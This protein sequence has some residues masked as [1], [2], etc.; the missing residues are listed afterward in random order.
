MSST[1]PVLGQVVNQSPTTY[2]RRLIDKPDGLRPVGDVH[3]HRE[4]RFAG[5]R[6][7]H[8]DGDLRRRDDRIGT[9]TLSSSRQAKLSIS[10]LDT[11]THTI[12][13][14]YNGD[15]KFLTSTT[16]L[17]QTV[18]QADTKTSLTSAPTSSVYGQSVT[19][20]ATVTTV[21][22]GKG[23]PVGKVESTTGPRSSGRARLVQRA[24]RRS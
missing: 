12:K 22:P 19:L 17:V 20:T 23:T 16:T 8:R 4:R 3:G 18:D 2:S 5:Q 10:A 14:T 9:G 11:G 6:H 15:A 24:R 13:A 21:S 1:S 7:P